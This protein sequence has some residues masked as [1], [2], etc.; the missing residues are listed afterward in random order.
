[1]ATLRPQYKGTDLCADFDCD[2]G[3]G[4]HIEGYFAY[5]VECPHCGTVYPLPY[6][7]PVT[8]VTTRGVHVVKGT[9]DQF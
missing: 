4:F 8:G 5:N 7:I 9:P 1:M 2:C 6:L 3:K